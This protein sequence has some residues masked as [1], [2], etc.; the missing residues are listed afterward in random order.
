VT[1]ERVA[2]EVIRQWIF[3]C[4]YGLCRSKLKQNKKWA[5]GES[6]IGYAY[7]NLDTAFELPIERPM[8]EVLMLIL[9]A[10]RGSEEF[11][12]HTRS[13]ISEILKNNDFDQMV[14]CLPEDEKKEFLHDCKL[15]KIIP[16]QP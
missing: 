5:A 6:E 10:G 7:Y 4:Y 2:Y 8:L 12:I 9:D 3:N 13:V 11:H 16:S 1:E 14:S 15:V